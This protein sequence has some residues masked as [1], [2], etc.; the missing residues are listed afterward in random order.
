M[1][2][3]SRAGS[4]YPTQTMR[5]SLRN[6]D[7]DV[8]RT[9]AS[10]P[11]SARGPRRGSARRRGTPRPRGSRS[12]PA[13]RPS[14]RPSPSSRP[15]L[16]DQPVGEHRV[17][18]AADPLVE[19]GRSMSTP[20]CTVWSSA[21]SRR[22]SV[23]ENGRP[24]SSTTSS[25]RTMRRP[26]SGG[27]R[28]RRGVDRE[29]AR[30]QRRGAEASSSA[31]SRIRTAASVPGKSKSVQ[32]RPDVERGASDQH[33]QPLPGRTSAIAARAISLELR[34]CPRFLDTE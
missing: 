12:R 29:Q 14:R 6:Q 1:A 21:Y 22:G 16:L 31:S 32:H 27:S 25:A 20:T 28:A 3:V 5:G 33:R 10:P 34:H 18:P 2:F 30:M 23:A 15:H 17:D 26:L 13:V 7:P 4:S 8:V 19:G 11:R 24:V 9:S